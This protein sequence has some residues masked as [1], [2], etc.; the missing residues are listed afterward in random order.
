MAQGA[1]NRIAREG[2]KYGI[3]LLLVT[4]RP[5]ELPDTALAQ[6]G[7]LI[8][9]RL[10]NSADQAKIRAALPDS[11]AGLAAVLP[12]LRT[13]EALISGEAL[14][15]PARTLVDLPDPMPAAEDPSLAPWREDATVPDM[16]P[17]IAAWR[18]AYDPRS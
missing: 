12:S 13:G 7:S 11:V 9:L 3:G 8:A 10:S 1:A 16:A 15:L 6:C 14:V 5:S 4:Q 18:G 2:R 17:A